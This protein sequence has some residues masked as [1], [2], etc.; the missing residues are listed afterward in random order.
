[1][2]VIYVHIMWFYWINI[3]HKTINKQTIQTTTTT[4]ITTKEEKKENKTL[5]IKW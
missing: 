3:E 5:E 4:T 2:K 1:M